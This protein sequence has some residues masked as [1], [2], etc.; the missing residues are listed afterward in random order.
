MQSW[1]HFAL[2]VT[3][4]ALWQLMHLGT[5]WTVVHNVTSQH[6]VVMIAYMLRSSCFCEI[7]ALCVSW[8]TYD[9]LYNIYIHRQVWAGIAWHRW[10]PSHVI[11]CCLDLAVS[12]IPQLIERSGLA[13]RT[14]ECG[15]YE[16]HL[17]N[18]T[19]IV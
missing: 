5:W 11:L 16:L 15:P 14:L 9:H 3:R 19:A 12:S 1:K 2:L 7:W 17:F 6:I 8:I 4:M 18:C 10:E 13:R